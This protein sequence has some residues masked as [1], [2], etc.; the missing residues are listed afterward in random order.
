MNTRAKHAAILGLFLGWFCAGC[1]KSAPAVPVPSD[2]QKFLDK[3]FE[4][5]KSKDVGKIREFS[6]YVSAADRKGMPE[7]SVKM[8]RETKGQFAA[9]G[10][11]RVTKEYGDFQSCSVISVKVTAITMA[12]LEGA[13]MQGADNLAGIHA[14][15]VCKAKFS[16]KH[17]AQIGLHLLKETQESEYSVL[18]WKYQ[19]EP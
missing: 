1:D 2:C 11:A 6:A 12:D 13:K 3:Y 16:K 8:M 10:F 18:A 19:A 9:D 5:V 14:E 15:I 7:E 17:S 4:A